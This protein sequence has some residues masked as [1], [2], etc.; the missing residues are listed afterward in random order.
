M[1]KQQLIE[2]VAT[3][4]KAGIASKAASERAV[5]AVL[6]AIAKGIKQDGEV[7]LIG[8]GTFK[9]KTRAA[10]TGRNPGT[11]EPIKIKAAKTVSFKCGAG[12]KDLAKKAKAK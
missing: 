5:N 8:F 12:L 10:R 7:Q 6:D 3:D 1:N 9:I 2:S 4:K 11:G